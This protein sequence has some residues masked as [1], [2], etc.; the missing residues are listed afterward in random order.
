MSDTQTIKFLRGWRA[1]HQ[2]ERAGFTKDQIKELERRG[3]RFKRITTQNTSTSKSD[4]ETR[5]KLQDEADLKRAKEA[6]ESDDYQE[7]RTAV[8]ELSDKSATGKKSEIRQKLEG[9]IESIS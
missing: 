9:V 6:L 1:Y 8:S 7:M 5:Q 2:G 3:V 4:P